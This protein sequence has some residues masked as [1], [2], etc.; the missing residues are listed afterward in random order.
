[1]I[2][3]AATAGI[4]ISKRNKPAIRSRESLPESHG[5]SEVVASRSR[6]RIDLLS[7]R[8]RS[9]WDRNN[10]GLPR[11]K[12]EIVELGLVWNAVYAYEDIQGSWFP[13]RPSWEAQRFTCWEK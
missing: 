4:E 11:K 3:S 8:L 7:R 1:M 12:S 6:K 5:Q 9:T 13:I 10:L 2:K